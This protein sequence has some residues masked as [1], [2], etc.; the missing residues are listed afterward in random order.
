[1]ALN[2][3]SYGASMHPVKTAAAALFG[4][5]ILFAVPAQAQAVR[6][7]D[8]SKAGNANKTVCKNAAAAAASAPSA[9][10]TA[11]VKAERHYDCS[12]AGNANKA[13]CKNAVAAAAATPAA[14][15]APAAASPSIFSRMRSLPSKMATPQAS[16]APA[17]AAA[18]SGSYSGKSITT[19]PAGATG[20]CKDGTYTHATHHSG[21][22]S[23]HGG[24]AKWMNG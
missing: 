10:A 24:V 20:Q 13:V 17:P 2:P 9:P 14:P 22:C 11:P 21:A 5:T 6:H 1:M 7:Y 18:P 4:C 12:K 23:S 16:R 3:R 15:P 19:S 8:C